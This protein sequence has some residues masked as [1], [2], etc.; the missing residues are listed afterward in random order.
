MTEQ[1]NYFIK[2]Q[3]L[4]AVEDRLS[5]FASNTDN[6]YDPSATEIEIIQL[7]ET[8]NNR[9]H[10]FIWINT[11]FMESVTKENDEYVIRVQTHYMESSSDDC[12]YEIHMSEDFQQITDIACSH[13]EKYDGTGYPDGLKGEEIDII[14]RVMAIID[15]YDALVNDRVYKKAMPYEEAEEYYN[16]YHE[17]P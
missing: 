3:V 10:I 16:T 6:I 4:E 12:V 5:V 8:Q 13:H 7:D 15:V 11:D 9:K 2:K 14:S 1:E 17:D